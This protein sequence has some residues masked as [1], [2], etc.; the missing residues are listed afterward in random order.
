[1]YIDPAIA[2]FA[3][4]ARSYCAW[5][6]GPPGTPDEEVRTALKHLAL[7]YQCA[8]ELPHLSGDEKAGCI[9]REDFRAVYLRF[10]VIP[11]GYYSVPLNVLEVPPGE[12]GLGDLSEDLADIWRDLKPPLLLFDAGHIDAAVWEWR[13]HFQAHWGAHATAALRALHAWWTENGG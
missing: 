7:L 3:A 8:L 6:E 12:T 4:A 2:R 11:V 10:A 5:A 1:M 9:S 13:F